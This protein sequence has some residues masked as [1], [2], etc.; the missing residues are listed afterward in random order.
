MRKISITIHKPEML[1][2]FVSLCRLMC[3]STCLDLVK[4]CCLLYKD[5]ISFTCI[6]QPIRTLLSKHL[7]SQ[8]L[9]E[10]LQVGSKEGLET[11]RFLSLS[12]SVFYSVSRCQCLSQ[13]LHS[14]ILETISSAPVTHARLVLDKKKPIPLKLLTPKIVEV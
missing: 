6:F 2:V 5:L 13:E 11:V 9:P 8:T 10:L 1:H 14:E 12:Q 7:S 4:R 3:L